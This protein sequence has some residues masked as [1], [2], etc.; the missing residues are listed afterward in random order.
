[1]DSDIK[2]LESQTVNDGAGSP[3]AEPGL[4]PAQPSTL[5]RIFV[6]PQGLRAGWSV[7]IF[8]VLFFLILLVGGGPAQLI[9]VRLPHHHP[10][11]GSR[12]T[13]P[14]T[15]IGEGAAVLPLIGAMA[16][17]GLIERRRILDY[18]LRGSR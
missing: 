5:H 8:F 12:M 7:A 4:T 11:T 14:P 10:S 2:P 9:I 18:N 1:M 17:I 6:G 16:I 13:P 15:I 3:E